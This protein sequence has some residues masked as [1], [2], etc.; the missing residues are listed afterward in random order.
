MYI[1]N[2]TITK[3]LEK[4]L[5]KEKQ[6]HCHVG[7]LPEYFPATT[8]TLWLR[9]CHERSI[10]KTFGKPRQSYVIGFS[11]SGVTFA[12]TFVLIARIN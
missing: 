9:L 12:R 4:F 2:N 11:A 5:M 10:L 3:L 7:P 6:L 1:S 8:T